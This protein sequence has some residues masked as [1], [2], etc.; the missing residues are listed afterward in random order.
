MPESAWHRELRLAVRPQSSAELVRNGISRKVLRGPTWRR[1]RRG[2]YVPAAAGHRTDRRQLT[3]AQRILDATPSTTGRAAFGA[4]TAAYVLGVDWL[5]GTDPHTMAEL[6]IDIIAA[7]LRRR[8]PPGLSYRFTEVPHGDIVVRDGLR[9]T[10]PCRTAFDGARWARTLEDAVVFIDSS[11]GFLPLDL[12]ELEAYICAHPQWTGVRQATA[13][14]KLARPGVMSTWETRLRLCWR[15]QADLPE[16]LINAPI[17]DRSGSLLG[18]ADLFDPDSAL[19]AE[20][21]GDQHREPEQHRLDN[22]REEKLES[23]NIVVVRSA[24][25]DLRRER[26]HLIDRLQDGYRRGQRRDRSQD[27]WSLR[28]P[29]WWLRRMQAQ[30]LRLRP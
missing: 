1:V 18:I 12:A 17:F 5:D 24:K 28:Q 6:P 19:V 26:R 25:A 22:I 7:D 30:S 2:F 23:A 11:I 29:D 15:L 27:R 20:F 4:W 9:V 10:S 3:T 21:D 16:P 13:A 14:V 8:Q